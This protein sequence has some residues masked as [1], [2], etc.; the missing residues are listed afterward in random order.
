MG[1]KHIDA[2]GGHEVRRLTSAGRREEGAV[3]T[4]VAIL[5]MFGVM[6]GLGALTVD[7]GNIN[8]DR[9]Q[10]QNGADSV[11]LAV[12]QHCADAGTCNPTDPDL[13]R[14]ASAN[15][16]TS[17]NGASEIRRVDGQTPAICGNGPGLSACPLSSA[18]DTRKLQECPSSTL[19]SGVNFVRVYTETKN[20][21][22]GANILPYSFGALIAGV[23][24]G[25]NQQ[26]C[27]AVAWGSPGSGSAPITLSYCEW[28]KA[29]GNNA[30]APV[31]GAGTY[32]PKPVGAAPGY[33]GSGQPAWPLW[34][35]PL[36]ASPIAGNEIIV[37]L[38]GSGSS[39][40]CHTWNGHD[41]PGGFGY[42]DTAASCKTTAPVG[43]WIQVDTG[44]SLPNTCDLRPYLNTVLYLPVFDCTARS[45]G[46]PPASPPSP[47]PPAAAAACQQGTG[48]NTWYHVQGYA[49]FYL[50]GYKTGG[51]PSDTGD[52]T[53]PL[54]TP[55]PPCSGSDRCISGW[56][57][58]GL[59]EAPIGSPPPGGF[60]FGVHV[61][62]VIG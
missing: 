11:A 13:Q 31:P 41:A 40:D 47:S 32:A 6:L 46:G 55:R 24:S 3:A 35:A 4:I 2:E 37:S 25:A 45:V 36:P 30:A 26:T 58:Q 27:A 48:N 18:P 44:N 14:L 12:A 51:G 5:F 50:S 56:F 20:G 17:V 62:K 52:R 15:A 19:P 53:N 9:R 22:T 43:G 49:G 57:I 34:A 21:A 38:Q 59:V 8:A 61:I 16:A 29:T 33:G 7:V 39:S 1:S 54:A 28:A 60:T 23:G 42:L 10:L